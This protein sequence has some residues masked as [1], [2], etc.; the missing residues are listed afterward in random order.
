M[1]YHVTQTKQRE[2]VANNTGLDKAHK[3]TKQTLVWEAF[4]FFGGENFESLVTAC[5]NALE[6]TN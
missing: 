2:Q 3:E 1:L 5:L 4:F 6:E